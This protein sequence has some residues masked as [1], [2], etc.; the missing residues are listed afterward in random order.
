MSFL[1]RAWRGEA[2]L[3]QIFWLGLLVPQIVGVVA[4][5]IGGFIMGSISTANGTPVN[6]TKMQEIVASLP[7]LGAF[8]GYYCLLAVCI[9]RCRRNASHAAWGWAALAVLAF[10]ILSLVSV[11]IGKLSVADAAP[12]VM[13]QQVSD[14]S[15]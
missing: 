5:L 3:W 2:K 6:P 10:F 8:L 1:K 7:W 12:Q 15:I 9:W 13:T 11:I 4:G 14:G